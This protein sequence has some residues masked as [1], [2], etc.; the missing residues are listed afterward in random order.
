MNKKILILALFIAIIL[1]IPLTPIHA[2]SNQNN[3]SINKPSLYKFAVDAQDADPPSYYSF[4]AF[5]MKPPS[6]TPM[7][8]PVAVNAIF[9]NSGVIPKVFTV[10]VPVGNYSLVILNA[11][12]R[13]TGGP[14]Y[15]RAFYIFA[16]GIPLLWG[17]TQEI[18][19]STAQ[20]DVTYYQKLLEGT[21]TFQVVLTNYIA[22]RIG[23][24]GY[25]LV[26]VTLYLYP[27][28]PIPGLPNYFIPL[29]V[30]R[31]GYSAVA[32]S[33]T[34]DFI[35]Q[36]ISLPAGTYR[37]AAVF[38]TEGSQFDEFWYANEPAPRNLLVFYDSY[39]AGV[40]NP[41]ETIYT[42]GI[43][44]FYWRPV[45]SI[46]T[47][48]FHSQNLIDLTPMLALGNNATISITMTNLLAALQINGVPY[49][50]WIVSGALLLW[51]DPTNTLQSGK[52]ISS[53]SNFLDSGP[54]FFAGFFGLVYQETGSFFLNNTAVL[55]FA[56]GTVYSSVVQEGSFDAYQTFNSVFQYA[57]LNEEYHELAVEKGFYNATLHYDISTPIT[58][59]YSFF[60]V[61]IT[62]PNVIPYNLTFAQ[63]GTVSL[64]LN[65]VGQ[66][67]FG[68]YNLTLKQFE[69]LYTY[70]GFS[71]I[72]EIIN[73]YG[74][75]RILGLTSN[76]AQTSKNLTAIYLVNNAGW[77]ELFNAVGVVKGVHQRAGTLQSFTLQYVTIG[78]TSS[79]FLNL[80]ISPVGY[81]QELLLHKLAILKKD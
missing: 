45:T 73:A 7:A 28:N 78:S 5:Q 6:T 31:F 33:P 69:N 80:A 70:G 81:Q 37:M 61:P 77:E 75:A 63:N 49:F 24:T 58:M 19:N 44:P 62:N 64:G 51:V 43:D 40:V 16:N 4:Q 46:N 22:P 47:L 76:F 29:F 52:L 11:S 71:G 27:G 36:N 34:N 30:N 54:L 35:S 59:T 10:N 9:N 8:V 1:L 17:S 57:K 32:L 66:V 48:A 12:I 21:V 15:D 53:N 18:L 42:G 38:Y 3:A 26:N 2:Y 55:N 50:R 14:Q 23:I 67:I 56:K 65:Y 79:A 25:Y 39:L 60:A 72:L 41:Y 20:A 68:N 13:E 74:G